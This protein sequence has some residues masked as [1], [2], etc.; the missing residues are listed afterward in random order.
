MESSTMLFSNTNLVPAFEHLDPAKEEIGIIIRNGLKSRML[1]CI[2][3]ARF[4]FLEKIIPKLHSE[5]TY[6]DIPLRNPELSLPGLIGDEDICDEMIIRSPHRDIEAALLQIK[7]PTLEKALSIAEAIVFI[8]RTIKG[9]LKGKDECER[10]KSYK[11]C[12]IKHERK[13]CRFFKVV[14]LRCKRMG[15]IEEA[16]IHSHLN[17][18]RILMESSTMLFSNANLVPAFEH[19]DPVKELIGIIIS[20]YRHRISSHVIIQEMDK[21]HACSLGLKIIP[22]LHSEGTYEDEI[23]ALSDLFVKDIHYIHARAGGGQT[24]AHSLTMPLRNP[25][26]SLPELI[27]NEDIC[28]EMIIRS[29]HR[30]IQAA[31]LQNKTPTL[32]KAISKAEAIVFTSMTINGSLKGKD[33]CERWKSCM[34]CFIKNE[35]KDCRF[36]KVVWH[37]CNRLGHMEEVGRSKYPHRFQTLSPKYSAKIQ[38]SKLKNIPVRVNGKVIPFLVDTGSSC[39]VINVLTLVCIE[40]ELQ[41][42][43]EKVIAPVLVVSSETCENVLGVDVIAAV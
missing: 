38:D 27:G 13:D 5:G 24:S 35:R 42:N 11:D 31:L 37:R 23:K 43:T 32:E 7:T 34:D 25:E 19:L 3:C 22:M 20:V 41:Y 17:Q 33:E 28:D 39:T 14:W 21:I 29:P 10:W 30:D 12:F 8:P 40:V 36:F 9:S 4:S 16:V 6:E 26:L 1:I 18:Q 15:H 2:G